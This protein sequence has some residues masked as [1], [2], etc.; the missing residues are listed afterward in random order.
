MD[1]LAPHVDEIIVVDTGS[2]DDTIALA[3]DR[4][5]KVVEIDWADDFAAA[6]NVAL[7][8]VKT[9]WFLSIDADEELICRR[10]RADLEEL[11]AA[12]DRV[13]LDVEDANQGGRVKIPRLFKN[14]PGSSWI[15]PVHE[16]LV[17]PGVLQQ[18]MLDAEQGLYLRHHGYVAE[19]NA[20]KIA[21]NLRILRRHLETNENEPGSLFFLA[22]ECA[23]CGEFAEGMMA[24]ERLLDVADLH[25]ILLADALALAQWCAVSLGRFSEAVDY[26]RQARRADVPTAWTEY[27][28][29]LAYINAGN[30]QKAIEAIDRACSLPYP[31]ESMLALTEV[32]QKKRFEL[33]RG[34]HATQAR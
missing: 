21:R 16:A 27:L 18:A 33:K 6:R 10:S 11:F 28:L 25:G 20:H 26:G 2:S 12:T 4:K 30:R 34:L 13:L 22:R 3:K 19:A 14:I 5:A 32:W 7:T 9:D 17:Q 23:W 15:R 24:A 8:N 1:S 31:E 29:S